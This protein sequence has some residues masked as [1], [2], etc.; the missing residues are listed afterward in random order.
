MKL[1]L[2][3]LHFYCDE[4]GECL[5]WNL[6][7]KKGQHPQARLE[8]KTQLVGR[9]VY[10][11]LMGRQLANGHRV[12]AKCGNPRCISPGCLQSQTYSTI[13]RRSYESGKRSRAGEYAARVQRAR[14]QGWVKLTLADVH[15][16]RASDETSAALAAKYNVHR[17]TISDARSGRH[18]QVTGASVFDTLRVA[19]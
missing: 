4:E 15:A 10:T 3:T 16:I 19:A 14:D 6:S 12:S 1:T 18:W 13:L 8:G 5:L 2:D 11:H 9:Y 7:A 17:K